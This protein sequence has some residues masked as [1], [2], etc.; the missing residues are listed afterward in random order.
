MGSA[1]REGSLEGSEYSLVFGLWSTEYSAWSL[2]FGGYAFPPVSL[3][4]AGDRPECMFI[5]V[6]PMKL[7]GALSSLS[8]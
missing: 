3:G 1:P 4:P 5:T 7:E 8:R 6:E 2:V